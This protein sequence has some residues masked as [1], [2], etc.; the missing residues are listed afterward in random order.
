MYNM[1]ILHGFTN[2][3]MC[4]YKFVCYRI[5]SICMCCLYVGKVCL[6]LFVQFSSVC[7]C[8][9]VCVWYLAKQKD[10]IKMLK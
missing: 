6:C 1:A 10:C 9:C 2:T 8:V 3:C 5:L 4:V 7:V